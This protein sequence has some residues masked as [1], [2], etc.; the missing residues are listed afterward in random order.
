[1]NKAATLPADRN[2]TAD[3][4]SGGRGYRNTAA[5]KAERD[6]RVIELCR[7]HPDQT[8]NR[9]AQLYYQTHGQP[10]HFLTVATIRATAGYGMGPDTPQNRSQRERMRAK[11]IEP[12]EGRPARQTP[13]EAPQAILSLDSALDA[14]EA[15]GGP[16]HALHVLD[17]ADSLPPGQFRRLTERLAALMSRSR[18]ESGSC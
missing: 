3:K 6:R 10:I 5:Y 14:I 11:R 4:P 8:T 18:P 1:M 15:V 17:A 16:Q 13:Q 7:L 12:A 2:G 9:I